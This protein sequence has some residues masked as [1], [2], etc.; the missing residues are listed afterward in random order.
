MPPR[1]RYDAPEACYGK[2]EPP[3]GPY[4]SDYQPV[5]PPVP[6]CCP[7]CRG[8][9]LTMYGDTRCVCCGW[10]RQPLPLPQE[11]DMMKSGP[12]LQHIIE[13]TP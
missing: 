5:Y 4:V 11:P 6:P 2:P 12:V 13:V 9:V 1:L 8:L 3:R 10:Y 7:R